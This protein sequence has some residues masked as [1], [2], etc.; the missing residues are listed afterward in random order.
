MS[1]GAETLSVVLLNRCYSPPHCGALTTL[2]L[3][4]E[5][6]LNFRWTFSYFFSHS[7]TRRQTFFLFSFRYDGIPVRTRKLYSKDFTS[8]LRVHTLFSFQIIKITCVI[9]PAVKGTVMCFML[10]HK[11][12]FQVFKCRYQTLQLP[13]QRCLNFHIRGL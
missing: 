5:G 3:A 13:H 2:L 7:N 4:G 11:S 12:R 9:I 8:I 10:S 6:R 1:Q